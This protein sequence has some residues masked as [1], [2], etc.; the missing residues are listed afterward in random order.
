MK[1]THQ[2][3]AR[4][5]V[6]PPAMTTKSTATFIVGFRSEVPRSRTDRDDV[7]AVTYSDSSTGRGASDRRM[8]CGM[9]SHFTGA[10]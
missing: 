5:V 2:R 10:E 9:N 8:Q 1:C 7:T 3:F 6:M 4:L